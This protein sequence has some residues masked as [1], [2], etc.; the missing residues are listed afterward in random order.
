MAVDVYFRKLL[1][2]NREVGIE[3][4]GVHQANCLGGR[5]PERKQALRNLIYH[6][7]HLSFSLSFR[8]IVPKVKRTKEGLEINERLIL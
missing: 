1:G 6:S 8:G 7:N 3:T 4:T 5:A 2:C